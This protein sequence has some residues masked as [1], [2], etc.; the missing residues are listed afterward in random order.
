MRE[1][2]EGVADERAAAGKVVELDQARTGRLTRMDAL[3]SQAMARA[4]QA[5]AKVELARIDAA[6]KRLEEGGFGA[7]L[8]CGEEI[9]PARLEADPTAPLCIDCASARE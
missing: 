6:L 1:A 5:R 3:Q 7:C 2:V 9:A 8:E 4:G